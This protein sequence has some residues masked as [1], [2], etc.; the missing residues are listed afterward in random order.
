MILIPTDSIEKMT[1][2]DGWR[3]ELVCG[4]EI[5]ATF[6]VA[7]STLVYCDGEMPECENCGIECPIREAEVGT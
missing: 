4:E 3:I 1:Y 7:E 6:F 5:L 2:R